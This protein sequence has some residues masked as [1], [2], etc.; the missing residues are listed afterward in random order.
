MIF[1]WSL[2]TI[3]RLPPGLE[4]NGGIGA[5]CPQIFD[6]APKL[7]VVRD[8]FAPI[9]LVNSYQMLNK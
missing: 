6:V 3:L 9:F 1:E 8:I 7:L 5:F 4:I 2:V